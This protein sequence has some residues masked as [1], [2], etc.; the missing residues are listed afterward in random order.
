MIDSVN[1]FAISITAIN[2]ERYFKSKYLFRTCFVVTNQVTSL[3]IKPIRCA[4]TLCRFGR[5]R[6]G[7]VATFFILLIELRRAVLQAAPWSFGT[8]RPNC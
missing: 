8:L 3:E 1:E 6:S 4:T 7:Y 5:T 2:R